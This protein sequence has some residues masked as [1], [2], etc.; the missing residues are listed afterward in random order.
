MIIFLIILLSV[1]LFSTTPPTDKFVNVNQAI[2]TIKYE[3]RYASN[4]N[5]I[6]RPID[7]YNAPLC[8]LS[9]ESAKALEKA[10]ELVAQ[11]G[12]RLKV[13][14]CYRPQRAV[15]DFVIWAKDLNDTKMKAIYYAN[16]PKKE[17]FRLGY[18]AAKSGHSRGSTLDLTIEGLEMGTPY[19]FFDKRSH[20]NDKSISIKAQHNR[21][22]LKQIM[23]KSGF[24]NYSKEWW[25]YT[26]KEE[27]FGEIYFDF[28]I[29]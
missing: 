1:Y 4:N 17:L 18:I 7:G 9:K 19:D 14:D 15:N 8:Y 5:F 2:P 24:V 13:Y 11:K 26:L 28:V 25:H 10:Q 16:V 22:Y 6:G 3:I 27:P 21:L 12:Y 23:Q 29:K 20:T